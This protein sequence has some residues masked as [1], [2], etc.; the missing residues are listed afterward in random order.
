MKTKTVIYSVTGIE[1]RKPETETEEIEC[2]GYFEKL[3]RKYPGAFAPRTGRVKGFEYEFE[4]VE[5]R[6]KIVVKNPRFTHNRE[7]LDAVAPV[8]REWIADDI[9]EHS[10]APHYNNIVIAK[11]KVK[12]GEI[13]YRVCVDFRLLNTYLK[14]P[15]NKAG[16]IESFREH[17][18]NKR[19]FTRLDLRN[20]FLSIQ[21]AEKSRPFTTFEYRG[22]RFQFKRIPFGLSCSMQAFIAATTPI[23]E[24]LSYV[25]QY[26]DDI[27]IASENLEEHKRHVEEVLRRMENNGM[28]LKLSKCE[29]ATKEITVLG[30]RVTNVRIFPGPDKVAQL[31]SIERLEA[32]RS[33]KSFLGACNYFSK[34]I[35]R[36]AE[37]AA[38]LTE[39]L[40]KGVKFE[41]SKECENAFQN[42]KEGLKQQLCN[43][44]IKKFLPID[45]VLSVTETSYSAAILQKQEDQYKCIAF[46]GRVLEPV[47]QRYST[48]ELECVCVCR[49]F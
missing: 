28:T 37:F 16:N 17:F 47:K 31:V 34:H 25:I 2:Q 26:V 43:H 24:D 5:D 12:P 39:L 13:L 21:L 29:F 3:V 7:K 11:K 44:H 36:Y 19:Y 20:A 45:V 48:P 38:K 8:I 35:P 10:D 27:V 49:K 1:Q 30:Y 18:D 9:I 22:E 14:D 32:P 41:W 33:I 6:R 46:V 40:K 42:I 15:T 23:F 4:L